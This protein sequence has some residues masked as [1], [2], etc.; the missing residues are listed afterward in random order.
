MGPQ[1]ASLA[2]RSHHSCYSRAYWIVKRLD[3]SH[4]NTLVF[5][6]AD[7]MLDM[8]FEDDI[9]ALMLNAFTAA[10]FVFCNLSK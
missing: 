2:R 6:E 5:D 8:G 1:I 4:L 9:D 7:R 10:T 3:L